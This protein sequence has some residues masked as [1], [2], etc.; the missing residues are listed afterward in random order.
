VMSLFAANSI[1]RAIQ[2]YEEHGI[3]LGGL[4]VNAPARGW[5]RDLVQRFAERLSTRVLATI[6]R[7]P[8]IR[9]AER[10]RRTVVEAFPRSR[11]AGTFRRLARTIEALRVAELPSPTPMGDVELVEFCRPAPAPEAP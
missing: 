9:E 11:A 4:L 10:A 1:A 3:R 6:P 2:A 8:R 5:D 7:S